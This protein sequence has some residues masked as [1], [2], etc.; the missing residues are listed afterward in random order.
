MYLWHTTPPYPGRD[1]GAGIVINEQVYGLLP[2][3]TVGPKNSGC[4]GWHESG[5]M[6]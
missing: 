3:L 5:S 6:G 1:M 2:H 4:L